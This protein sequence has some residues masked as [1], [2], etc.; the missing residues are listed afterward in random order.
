MPATAATTT[1]GVVARAVAE[2][3]VVI[4][5]R[6]TSSRQPGGEHQRARQLHAGRRLEQQ[7]AAQAQDGKHQGEDEPGDHQ[8]HLARPPRWK[9]RLGRLSDQPTG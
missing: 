4:C 6:T 2:L 5:A 1:T 7:S 9:T 3:Q 8:G